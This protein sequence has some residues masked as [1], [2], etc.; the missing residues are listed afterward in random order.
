MMHHDFKMYGVIRDTVCWGDGFWANNQYYYESGHI[1]VRD[2]TPLGTRKMHGVDLVVLEPHYVDTNF[3]QVCEGES[4]TYFGQS[5]SSTGWHSVT[6]GSDNSPPTSYLACDT[7][8][9]LFLTV[10]N[11]ESEIVQNGTNFHLLNPQ[12]GETYQWIDATTGLAISGA[13]S[14]SYTPT[15]NGNYALIINRGLCNEQSN[16]LEMMGIGLDESD[17][18]LNIY[19]NPFGDQIHVE[20]QELAKQVNIKCYDASA[21]LVFSLSKSN[22][23]SF[24][25][26]TKALAKGV[27]VLELYIDDQFKVKKMIKK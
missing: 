24:D 9:K 23:S 10:N 20:L 18:S 16:T 8:H 14:S 3:A 11:I 25:V 22:C 21:Q 12:S 5:F 6:F 27:Y 19:P 15:Q 2:T 1:E 7:V 26:D 4:Y 17:Y 13:T